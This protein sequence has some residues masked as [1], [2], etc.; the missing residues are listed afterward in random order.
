MHVLVPEHNEAGKDVTDDA[1]DE[2]YN[3]DNCEENDNIVSD[4]SHPKIYL[5]VFLFVKIRFVLGNINGNI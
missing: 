5:K 4:M 3:V 1:R 2:D